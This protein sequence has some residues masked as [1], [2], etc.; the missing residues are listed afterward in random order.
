MLS[1]SSHPGSM[2]ST[3]LVRA[4]WQGGRTV[5]EDLRSEPPVTLRPTRTGIA[6]VGSAAGPVGGDESSLTVEVGSG[7]S[8]TVEAVAATMLFPGRDGGVSRQIITIRVGESG[9]LDWIAQPL[10]S[11]VGSNH[12]QRVKIEL[13]STA[14]LNFHDWIVL[15]RSEESGGYLEAQIRVERGGRPLLHQHQ[16]FDPESPGFATTA[17]TGGFRHF[18]QHLTV[19][20]VATE[21]KTVTSPDEVEMRVPLADDVELATAL[22][23]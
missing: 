15:G 9:H 19:G 12:V 20:P 17:S 1:G 7:A 21:T 16:V 10:L 6:L 11:V 8:L 2:K 5:I 22:T 18:Q 3:S 23:R 13:A 4:A 14:T